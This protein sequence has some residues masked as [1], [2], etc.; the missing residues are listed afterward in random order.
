MSSSE[1]VKLIASQDSDEVDLNTMRSQLS[2]R[3]RRVSIP[4]ED[5]DD[6]D[7]A[8]F[9]PSQPAKKEEDVSDEPDWVRDF[10]QKQDEDEN[11]K[12]ALTS[13]YVDD[14]DSLIDLL[15]DD[16]HKASVANATTDDDTATV[17][18]A[19]EEK[20]D[21][22]RQPAG[23]ATAAAAV[24]LKSSLALVVG[25]KMDESLVLVQGGD[26]DLDLS[27][28]VGAVGRVKIADGG[29]YLDIKGGMYQARSYSTNTMAVVSIV[30]DE[31]RITAVLEEAV[32]LHCK[33]NMFESHEVLLHG[34]L[35]NDLDLD[36]DVEVSDKDNNQHN[37]AAPP[38]AKGTATGKAGKIVK[39]KGRRT[40]SSARKGVAK[41]GRKKK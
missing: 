29:L 15:S 8:I 10:S 17:Q 38:A 39:P 3:R 36:N 26:E 23:K 22:A 14:D 20:E 32:L 5:D 37:V 31:A 2:R 35:G 30:D 1:S 34:D 13:L 40:S 11:R 12:R 6:D 41:V 4:I 21:A 27:G 7:D 28:D 9:I 18:K 24:A 33:R 25:A 16:D 19:K